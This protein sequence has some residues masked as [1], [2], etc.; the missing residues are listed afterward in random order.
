MKYITPAC[1]SKEF[2]AGFNLHRKY[3]QEE[4][5][6]TITKRLVEESCELIKELM[7]LDRGRTERNGK[8]IRETIADEYA[9]LIL[10]MEFLAK[11]LNFTQEEIQERI[12]AKSLRLVENLKQGKI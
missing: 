10:C 6:E 4:H 5:V 12:T 9:D 1:D 7:K 11:A 8:P 3:W 2:L